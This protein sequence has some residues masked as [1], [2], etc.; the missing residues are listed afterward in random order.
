MGHHAHKKDA[1]DASHCAI[2]TA[3]DTRD[4]STDESGRL[5]RQLLEKEGHRVVHYRILKDEPKEIVAA[6]REFLADNE[7]D[8]ILINGGT[9]V[10]RRDSTFEAIDALLEKRLPGFGELF[11][12]LSYLEIGSSAMLS[13]ATAGIVAERAV[14][15]VP[16]SVAA[17]R[18]AMEK[19]ILPELNHIVW[20]VRPERS[21]SDRRRG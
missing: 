12:Y 18:L 16:G 4:E 5:I 17:V 19:L 14:F 6:V 13:R 20:L 21:T 11:R 15:S 9:G 1:P 8:A 2:I 7:V 3:S 10:A